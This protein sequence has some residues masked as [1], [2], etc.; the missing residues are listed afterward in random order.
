MLNRKEFQDGSFDINFLDEK[1]LP[2]IPDRW[3]IEDDDQYENAV[4][5]LSSLLKYKENELSPV[6]IKCS[7][8]NKWN[9]KLSE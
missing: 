7:P 4:Y 3:K 6:Q 5:I 9:D 1:F 2:L 8:N